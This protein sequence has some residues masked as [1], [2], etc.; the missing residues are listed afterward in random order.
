MH[1]HGFL[2]LINTHNVQTH[3]Q[4]QSP[5]H[6]APGL[7]GAGFMRRFILFR[8]KSASETTVRIL[9]RTMLAASGT[10]IAFLLIHIQNSFGQMSSSGFLLIISNLRKHS[11]IKKLKICSVPMLKSKIHKHRALFRCFLYNEEKDKLHCRRIISVLCFSRS[12]F[13]K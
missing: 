7:S 8:E 2:L 6:R 9:C 13:A 4:E 5:L 3:A 1:M 10:G 11:R 12:F